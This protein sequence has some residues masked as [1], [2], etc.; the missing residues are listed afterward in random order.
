MW[1]IEGN[2][3]H[4]QNG[5]QFV[6]FFIIVNMYVDFELDEIPPPSF[7]RRTDVYS[8]W[9]RRLEVWLYATDVDIKKQ[10]SMII[11]NLDEDTRQAI[12]D[13]VSSE[14]YKSEDGVEKVLE[15]LDQMFIA[16]VANSS[17]EMSKYYKHR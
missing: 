5:D 4:T 9:K 16:K 13:I 15:V 6:D 17:T 2:Y 11:F 12:L 7:D 10:A 1:L 3:P 14:K 8:K